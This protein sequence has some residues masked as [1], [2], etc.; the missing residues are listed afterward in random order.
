MTLTAGPSAPMGSQRSGP[1]AVQL[2]IGSFVAV[3]LAVGV[4][5]RYKWGPLLETYFSTLELPSAVPRA[6]PI[7]V[8]VDVGHAYVLWIFNRFLSDVY[9]YRGADRTI[10]VVIG[11]LCFDV[12]ALLSLLVSNSP[13]FQVYPIPLGLY[14]LV[15]SY[16]HFAYFGL[17]V[18][19]IALG[20]SL[21]RAPD[22]FGG[23]L[24][25]YA[26]VQIATGVMLAAPP[27]A[28]L[29]PFVAAAGHALM[30]VMLFRASLNPTTRLVGARRS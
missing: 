3:V 6:V 19:L 18:A 17:G 16:P 21:L 22:D 8:A 4:L 9:G 10:L 26:Q 24:R 11:I 7:Y 30:A 29:W 12:I 23:L 25:L 27:L 5:P 28:G 13:G 2:T 1:T 20:Y 15:L 14:G